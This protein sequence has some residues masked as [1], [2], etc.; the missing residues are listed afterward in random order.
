MKPLERFSVIFFVIFFGIVL[1][2]DITEYFF[3]KPTNSLWKYPL[4]LAAAG[5]YFLSTSKRSGYE[6]S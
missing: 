4:A 2:A 3:N 6:G 5:L 1:N